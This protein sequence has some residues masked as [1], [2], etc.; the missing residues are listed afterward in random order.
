[1]G[2]MKGRDG[3][4]EEMGK[5]KGRDGWSEEMGER[6]GVVGGLKKCERGRGRKV[7]CRDGK[8]G[9]ER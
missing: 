5:R 9:G 3:W 6:M 1:M 4:S 2:K 7:V 8:E